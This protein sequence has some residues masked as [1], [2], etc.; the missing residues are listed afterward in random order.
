M[1]ARA[2]E[3]TLTNEDIAWLLKLRGAKAAN[4]L[5]ADIPTSVVRK[6]TKLAYA[7]V[8]SGGCALTRIDEPRAVR[9]T[10]NR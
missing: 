3:L 9:D 5:P 8:S 4:Q 7:E 1:E 6:L 2:V 10:P